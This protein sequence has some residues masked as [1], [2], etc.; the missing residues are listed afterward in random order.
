[1]SCYP[2]LSVK[3]LAANAVRTDIRRRAREQSAAAMNELL[4]TDSDA[5]WES[6][7]PHLDAALG[8]LS[9]ADRDALLLRYFER[10][11][12]R[13]MAERL[14]TSEEAA[15]KRVSRAVEHLRELL[16]KRGV[17]A[18]AGAGSGGLAML[19][20]AHAVQA[21]PSGL[22][23]LIST[24]AA[25]GG[26]VAVSNQ[27]TAPATPPPR[28]Q[29]AVGQALA[30]PGLTPRF[31]ADYGPAAS[32]FAP[33]IAA[34][35]NASVPVPIQPPP[36]SIPISRTTKTMTW[37]ALYWLN[38]GIMGRVDKDLDDFVLLLEPGQWG[39]DDQ[40]VAHMPMPGAADRQPRSMPLRG[41]KL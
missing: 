4:S 11:T 15:Q 19:I 26:G 9:E 36:A 31:E 8:E 35:Q 39:D 5:G 38:G 23:L 12:A 25:V 29:E 14:G 2:W 3:Y 30:A 6:I 13:Q 34:P 16:A 24:S 17:M 1:M 32:G 37:K 40:S 21:G 27:P 20:A 7:A 10:Q 18:G 22:A 28:S 41:A 33:G